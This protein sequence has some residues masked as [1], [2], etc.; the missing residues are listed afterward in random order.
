[1]GCSTLPSLFAVSR[2]FAPVWVLVLARLFHA[3][4]YIFSINI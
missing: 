4:F 1:L 3:K 2:N